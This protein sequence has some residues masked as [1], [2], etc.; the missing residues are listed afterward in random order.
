MTASAMIAGMTPLALGL[1][2][3]GSQVAPLGQAVIGGL[4]FSTMASLLVLP[5]FY[6]VIQ[7]RAAAIGPSLDPDDPG[8]KYYHQSLTES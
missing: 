5:H 4:I 8:S 7:H 6:A 3:G 1:G 2:D